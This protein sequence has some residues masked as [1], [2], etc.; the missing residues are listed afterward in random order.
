MNKNMLLVILTVVIIGLVVGL[1]TNDKSVRKSTQ[2]A[3]N[4]LETNNNLITKTMKKISPNMMVAD[5]DATVDYYKEKLSFKTVM[6]VDEAKG[7]GTSGK[8]LVWAM[9][10]NGDVEIM[11]QRKD[12]FIAELPEMK[13]KKMGGTFTLYISMT[14]IK[15]FYEK[16][17]NEVKIVK[18]LHKT[19]YG[20]DEFVVKDLN[21]YIIYFAEAQGE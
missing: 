14:D 8:P 16:I 5:V 20:A 2:E 17:K 18:E 1:V 6:V 7:D 10:K 11:F 13:D 12:G 15:D 9:L 4:N 21:G 19:W 3:K